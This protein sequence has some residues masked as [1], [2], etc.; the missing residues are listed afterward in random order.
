MVFIIIIIIIII[1]VIGLLPLALPYPARRRVGIRFRL[2]NI[3]RRETENSSSQDSTFIEANQNPEYKLQVKREKAKTTNNQL[4]E[5]T[6]L[7]TAKL[8]PFM[9]TGNVVLYA[10]KMEGGPKTQKH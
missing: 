10:M 4:A 3:S 5:G 2:P 1:R 7:M 8:Q 9:N 6:E